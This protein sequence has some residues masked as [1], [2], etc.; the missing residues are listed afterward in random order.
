M[1]EELS[2]K[3]FVTHESLAG[4]VRERGIVVED[5]SDPGAWCRV[6]AQYFYERGRYGNQGAVT[7]LRREGWEPMY[8]YKHDETG[9]ANPEISEFQFLQRIRWPYDPVGAV[10]VRV[11]GCQGF[12]PSE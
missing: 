9:N 5:L 10:S 4:F 1:S 3:C 7:I 2:D 11:V 8:T 6:A 12:D